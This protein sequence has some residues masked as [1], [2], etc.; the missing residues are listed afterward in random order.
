[1]PI[2]E[3]AEPS[4]G[5]MAGPARALTVDTA[6]ALERTMRPADWNSGANNRAFYPD[7]G[8][9]AWKRQMENT[10]QAQQ[11]TEAANGSA[12]MPESQVPKRKRGRPP[13]SNSNESARASGSDNVRVSDV[14]RRRDPNPDK[15][16]E[17]GKSPA[18]RGREVAQKRSDLGSSEVIE[19]K[20]TKGRLEATLG[21][22]AFERYVQEAPL[23]DAFTLYNEFSRR[24]IDA[25]NQIEARRIAEKQSENA[26]NF[27]DHVFTYRGTDVYKARRSFDLT[28]GRVQTIM[29]C[30]RNNCLE[31]FDDYVNEM[32][33]RS[34]ANIQ[35]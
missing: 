26:C 19:A 22:D 5:A 12:A 11:S 32:S 10:E 16:Q 6:G 15:L 24:I 1:M 34:R 21:M 31:K 25:G 4:R 13:K 9:L 35:E 28:D 20:M 14:S 2:D 18:H 3:P 29:S 17:A 7:P 27:C 8:E 30:A 33:T 23:K